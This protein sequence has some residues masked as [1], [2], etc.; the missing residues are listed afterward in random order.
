MFAPKILLGLH[1]RFIYWGSVLDLWTIFVGIAFLSLVMC[2]SRQP[3]N[4][5]T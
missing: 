2:S 5:R 4:A 1:I 3:E